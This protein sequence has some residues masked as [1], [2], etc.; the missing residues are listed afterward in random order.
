MD[1]PAIDVPALSEHEQRVLIMVASGLKLS[2]VA[3]R[4]GTSVHVVMDYL[5]RIRAK[6]AA[7]GRPAPTPR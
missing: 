5:K 4:L 6:H 1:S 2:A 7:V 3:R